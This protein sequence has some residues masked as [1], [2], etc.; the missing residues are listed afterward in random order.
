MAE[1]L[2]TWVTTVDPAC[3]S[4]IEK[5][6]ATEQARLMK[7][8]E[9]LPMLHFASLTLF[10]PRE[11]AAGSTLI[12]E[13]NIDG[14]RT[15]YIDAL[16]RNCTPS[17]DEIY[18]CVTG[19]PRGGDRHEDAVAEFLRKHVKR[20][21]LYHVGHPR[22][23][24]RA[25]AGD[26][27]L[28]RSIEHELTNNDS[29][30]GLSPVDQLKQLRTSAQC[31][32][33]W[34]QSHYPWPRTWSASGPPPQP[35]EQ[36]TPLDGFVWHTEG[37]PWPRIGHWIVLLLFGLVFEASLAIVLAWSFGTPLIVSFF[38]AAIV[39]LVA[40]Q[41]SAS[42]TQ[43]LHGLLSVVLVALATRWLLRVLGIS[44]A[45]EV[46][47][48]LFFVSLV[49]VG[50]LGWLGASF[51]H[52]GLTLKVT[53]PTA[54]LTRADRL[55][56]R[57]LLEAEDI[58]E[59]HSIY[60]HVTGYSILKPDR[61]PWRQGRT[62]L[63]LLL[64]NLFY[65]TFFSK[66]KLASI[67][68]IHFA[69]W[70]LVDDHVVFLTNYDGSADSY[71]DDFFNSLAQGVAFIWYDTQAFPR[72]SDPRRLKLWVRNNQ[73]LAAIRY[74]ATVYDGMTVAMIN[75]NTRIRKGVIGVSSPASARRWLRLF[76]SANIPEPSL[77]LRV[78]SSLLSLINAGSES[79]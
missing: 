27:E 38:L 1:R 20:A 49:P 56:L 55:H 50:V 21:T 8:F 58:S 5:A 79:R 4:H 71:L 75:T 69:Q 45:S 7:S 53:A 23:S 77:L 6:L 42:D 46:P 43:W 15:P 11:G 70:R 47:D 30:R 41:K 36:P 59:R 10:P 65:R 18:G 67:P 68:S 24:V 28:R 54:S 61:M 78:A 74:R 73:V 66:G 63:V 33:R 40:V 35:A 19:Y 3:A 14:P 48:W 2:F 25:I 76:G 57:D 29:L 62:R 31:P 64:L 17:L 26:R 9:Q 16:A 34:S 39:I 22:R 60:N 12:F 32:H 51:V 13:C 52:I 44:D 72:T 37:L